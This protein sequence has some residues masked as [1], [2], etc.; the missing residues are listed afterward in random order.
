MD[1][2]EQT[3]LLSLPSSG[4]CEDCGRPLRTRASRDRG[5]G[6]KCYARAHPE[7]HAS[8]GR[9]WAPQ[10]GPQLEEATVERPVVVTDPAVAYGRPQVARIGVEHIAGATW[11]ESVDV[12]ADEYG[13]TRPQVLVA[14]WWIGLYGDRRW[15]RRWKTWAQQVDGEL[16]HSRYEIPDPPTREEAP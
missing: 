9:W 11:V 5:K 7:W 16:W 6:P 8:R 13:L 12:A 2:Y 4:T 1:T 14:C 10:T 15:R 3:G